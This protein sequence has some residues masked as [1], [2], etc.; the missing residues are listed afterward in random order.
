MSGPIA[1]YFATVGVAVDPKSLTDVDKYLKSIEDRVKKNLV[2]GALNISLTADYK[3]FAN[4]LQ[5]EVNKVF[6]SQPF[7]IH[8]VRVNPARLK[9]SLVNG[10]GAAKVDITP[11]A[12][13]ASLRVLRTQVKAALQ[14][15]PIF[16]RLGGVTGGI[17]RSY[18]GV[19]TGS[20]GTYT[21]EEAARRRA[22]RTGRGD[23]SM[24]ER[25]RGRPGRDDLSA[26]NRRYYD[27]TVSK[28]LQGM[29]GRWTGEGTVLGGALHGGLSLLGNASSKTMG[30]RLGEGFGSTFLAPLMRGNRATASARGGL[31]GMLIGAVPELVVKAGTQI[32]GAAAATVMAPFRL[33]GSAINTVTSSFYR[34]AQTLLPFGIAGMYIDKKVRE[35]TTQGI[36]IDT[37]ARRYGSTGNIERSWLRGVADQAGANMGS[38]V[39]PFASFISASSPSM[40]L[41]RSKSVFASMTR[42][43]MAHG[44]TDYSMQNALKAFG[45]MAGKGTV[46]LEELDF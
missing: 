1:S 37:T 20:R 36:A 25:V 43:G 44:A 6:K 2:K 42:Y 21:G 3:K 4:S 12:S 27:A 45:Q 23:P 29:G 26:A 41:E 9:A 14:Q 7:T 19:G 35:S 40:G 17:A 30:G 13:Q 32:W 31:A 28:S 16:L 33:L 15:M 18:G 8:N 11:T 39:D 34:L 24:M 38:L 46:Q 22:S 5:R 10:L